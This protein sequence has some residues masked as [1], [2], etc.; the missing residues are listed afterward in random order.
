MH[1]CKRTREVSRK[2]GTRCRG[3]FLELM[4]PSTLDLSCLVI[5]V[6]W[7]LLLKIT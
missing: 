3:V 2:R 4:A 7:K 1:E 5:V 6:M